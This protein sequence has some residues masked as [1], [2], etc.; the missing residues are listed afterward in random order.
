LLVLPLV[1]LLYLFAEQRRA[2]FDDAIALGHAY[3]GTA[4]LLGDVIEADDEYTGTHSRE[5]V[6]LVIEVGV[7]LGLTPSGLR[8]AELT[9]LLHDVGKIRV[10]S[11]LINKA[12]PLDDAEWEV[13]R[14]HTIEGEKMLKQVGGLLEDVGRIVRSSHER[15]DGGGYPDGKRGEEI[16]LIARIVSCCDAFDA[17][18]SD[19]SYRS[20]MSYEAA[21]AELGLESGKQFDPSV[22]TSLVRVLERRT[23][24]G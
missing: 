12:G 10:P 6:S 11:E 21:I 18:T 5:V 13:I 17:M 3:Q 20:A 7:D 1:G 23:A 8:D 4:Y 2:H 22:V 19:R 15:W 24:A 9:A 16:P 14:R